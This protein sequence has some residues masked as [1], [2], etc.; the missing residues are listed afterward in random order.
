MPQLKLS[1]LDLAPRHLTILLELLA[2]HAAEAEVWAYGSRVEGGAHEGSD[3]D[4]VLRNPAG[5]N[6][7]VPG[8]LN[9]ESAL[10]ES[11][12]PMLV[13]IHDWARLPSDF[14]ENI[15]RCHI[16]LQEPALSPNPGALRPAVAAIV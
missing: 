8:L 5:P 3:L 13:E 16:V 11:C 6:V 9:F 4:L 1:A 2:Q 12:L 15:E 7:P 10:Q 14:H